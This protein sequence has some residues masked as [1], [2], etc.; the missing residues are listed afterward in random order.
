MGFG[1]YR[2]EK[3]SLRFIEGWLDW[4]ES[5]TEEKIRFKKWLSVN[6]FEDEELSDEPKGFE[7]NL[8]N[9]SDLRGK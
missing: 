6:G 2:I 4:P 3:P 8:K 9:Y 7:V 1:A 5:T